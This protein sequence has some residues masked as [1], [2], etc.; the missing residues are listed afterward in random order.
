[1][2]ILGEPKKPIDRQ[3]IMQIIS[4]RL[5]KASTRNNSKEFLTLVKLYLEL[6]MPNK[7]PDGKRTWK[8]RPK[9]SKN[10]VS[11]QDKL[12]KEVLELEAKGEVNGQRHSIGT[13][14]AEREAQAETSPSV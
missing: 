12:L 8:G 9:G 1:M 3:E 10:K 5:R 11:S 7:S 14:E 13:V 6:Q 4:D 2:D